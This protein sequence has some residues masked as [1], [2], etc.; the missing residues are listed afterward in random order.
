MSRPKEA[1]KE[2]TKEANKEAARERPRCVMWVRTF[3]LR[4]Q[5]G[6][7]FASNGCRAR[8]NVR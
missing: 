6:I 5:A 7:P 2:A 4:A 1:T 8:L 3:A